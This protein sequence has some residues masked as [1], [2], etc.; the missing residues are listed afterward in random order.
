MLAAKLGNFNY[1]VACI[2]HFLLHAFYFIAK[3]YRTGL[4]RFGKK[5][6]QHDRV[7]G[8]LNSKYLE[9]YLL[10]LPDYINYIF[11]ILP[12]HRLGGS[13]GGLVYRSEEHTSELQSR[14]N[15]VCR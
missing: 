10:K 7:L 5:V 8:L 3:Y 9:V 11:R 13:K 12:R 15:L 6:L 14:E 4:G 1:P 2:Y